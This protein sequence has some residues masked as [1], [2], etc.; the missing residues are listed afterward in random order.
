VTPTVPALARRS[1]GDPCDDKTVFGEGAAESS[2][3]QELE[4]LQAVALEA[5][6]GVEDGE[7]QAKSS[8]ASRL[9]ALGGHVTWRVHRVLHLG[10]QKALGV[11][12][13][14]YR[15]NLGVISTGYI[16]LEGLDDEGAE[17]EMNRQRPC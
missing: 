14:H 15:F 2:S 5:C 9:R 17:V 6:Q 1:S 7:V 16:I 10:V 11:V 8:M 4:D 3:Q 12:A 13:S